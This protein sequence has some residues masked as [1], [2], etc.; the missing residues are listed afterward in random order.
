MTFRL[1]MTGAGAGKNC[2][3]EGFVYQIQYLLIEHHK[4]VL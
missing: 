4:A 1:E 3:G 2:V